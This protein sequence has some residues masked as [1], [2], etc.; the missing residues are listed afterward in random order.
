MSWGGGWRA[1][2]DVLGLRCTEVSHLSGGGLPG[3][4]EGKELRAG[5]DPRLASMGF[6]SRAPGERV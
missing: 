3:R 5:T 4:L 2:R 1:L 6:P